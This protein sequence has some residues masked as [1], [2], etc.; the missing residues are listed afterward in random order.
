[1]R[2]TLLFLRDLFKLITI[3][4]MAMIVFFG[5]MMGFVVMGAMNGQVKA[6]GSTSEVILHWIIANPWSLIPLTAIV[7]LGYYFAN[8]KKFWEW[9]GN[10]CDQH[11]VY[12]GKVRP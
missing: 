3:L 4:A 10:V 9:W 12:K 6:S 5:I 8:Q 1:M 2:K 7:V 11:L